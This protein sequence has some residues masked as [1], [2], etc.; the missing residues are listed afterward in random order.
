MNSSEQLRAILEMHMPPAAVSYSLSLWENVPFSFKVQ[1]PRASKLGD[2]RYRKDRK[3]QTITI[4]SDLNPFQFLLT[5]IHE[6]AHLYTFENHGFAPAPHGIEW[7]RKF[8]SLMAPMLS[9]AVFPKDILIPLR[10]HMANPSASSARDL[11]LM[12][13]MSKYDRPT[14]GKVEEIF[15]SDLSTGRQ[16]LLS[17]RKFQKGETRRTRVLCEEVDSG[18]KYLVSRLAKV[19]PL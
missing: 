15:L 19:E 11:F 1:R 7:K 2:F 16:F 9:D 5:Y 14:S 18:R 17:G 6:V 12:K 3:I 8:Q 4:N 10:H 13:E